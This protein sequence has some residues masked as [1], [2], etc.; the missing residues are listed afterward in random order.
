MLICLSL[1]CGIC[2]SPP[3]PASASS[4]DWSGLVGVNYK[5]FVL[6]QDHGIGGPPSVEFPVMKAMGFNVIRVPFSWGDYDNDPIGFLAKVD[7]I[8]NYADANRISVYWVF[9][10]TGEND[11]YD[12]PSWL[13]AAYGGETNQAFLSAWWENQVAY[14][15][16]SGWILMMKDFWTPIIQHT[17]SHPSTIGYE[18]FNEP[19]TFSV[20]NSSVQICYQYFATQMRTMTQKAVIFMAANSYGKIS[21]S[22]LTAV[23]PTGISNI[24]ADLHFYENWTPS[25]VQ[26]YL[27]PQVSALRGIG[28]NQII[29]GEWGPNGQTGQWKSNSNPAVNNGLQ[30]MANAH[31]D[32]FSFLN[33]TEPVF[34]SLGLGNTYWKWDD[35]K[36]D[37]ICDGWLDLLDCNAQPWWYTYLLAEEGTLLYSGLTTTLSLNSVTNSVTS[38]ALTTPG[39]PTNGVTSNSSTELLTASSYSTSLSTTTFLTTQSP[40]K[41]ITSTNLSYLLNLPL[42]LGAAFVVVLVAIAVFSISRRVWRQ[43]RPPEH[44]H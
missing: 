37:P 19:T 13:T 6:S 3:K 16:E 20:P 12:F 7:D 26:S 5:H 24:V 28:I 22:D 9:F 27:G 34:R 10:G 25:Q 36:G 8:S 41:T 21:P 15:G 35:T 39:L 38:T 33:N 40:T 29:I 11:N 44:A 4:V 31:A 23:A 2:L 18:M 14:H 30:A 17:D 42:I 1:A 32:A 43:A